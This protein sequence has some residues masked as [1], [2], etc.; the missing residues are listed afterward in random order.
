LSQRYKNII[1][2][3]Q[4]SESLEKKA[5]QLLQETKE[6]VEKMILGLSAKK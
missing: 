3:C 6:K 5:N 1:S 4:K 2:Y